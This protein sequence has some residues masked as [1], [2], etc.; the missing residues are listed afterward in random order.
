MS[1]HGAVV[2]SRSR[3]VGGACRELLAFGLTGYLSNE[4]ESACEGTEVTW[5][6]VVALGRM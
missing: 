5:C 1:C 6:L 4:K 2:C 3:T